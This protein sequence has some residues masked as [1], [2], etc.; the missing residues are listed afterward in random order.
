[1]V[2]DG[3]PACSLESISMLTRLGVDEF[4]LYDSKHPCGE[5]ESHPQDRIRASGV[6]NQQN[7]AESYIYLTDW[8]GTKIRQRLPVFQD[9]SGVRTSRFVVSTAAARVLACTVFG[10]GRWTKW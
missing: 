9:N 8:P 2:P 1:L 5:P 3:Q 7:G 6:S 10:R 4:T